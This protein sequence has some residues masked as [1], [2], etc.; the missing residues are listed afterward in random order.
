MDKRLEKR[1]LFAVIFV[2]TIG[3]IIV[4][5]RDVGLGAILLIVGLFFTI[6]CIRIL[7][8]IQIEGA[9]E[10]QEALYRQQNQGRTIYVPLVDD[11]GYDLEPAIA[12]QRLA[13]ARLKAGPR[14]TVIG[15]RHKTPDAD[16]GQEATTRKPSAG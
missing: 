13:E 2:V 5:I 9:S 11:R 7:Q 3:P 6:Q 10:D 14:D 12:E 1:L 15:V 8:A 4:M 16:S